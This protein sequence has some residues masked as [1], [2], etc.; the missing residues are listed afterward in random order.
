MGRQHSGEDR[1]GDP[2]FMA[3]T[4]DQSI[5]RIQAR[6]PAGFGGEGK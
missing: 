4:G 5:S 1:E 3:E 2:R 6:V